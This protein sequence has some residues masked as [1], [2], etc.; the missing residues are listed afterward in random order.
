[1]FVVEG[2]RVVEELTRSSLDIVGVLAA[3]KLAENER[4]AAA[5]RLAPAV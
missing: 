3:P 2:V 1:M 4:G 5:P